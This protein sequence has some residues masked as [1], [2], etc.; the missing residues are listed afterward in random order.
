MLYKDSHQKL[1]EIT[2][3]CLTPPFPKAGDCQSSLLHVNFSC[4]M[5]VRRCDCRYPRDGIVFFLFNEIC[6]GYSSIKHIDEE[7]FDLCKE[8]NHED[9]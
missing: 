9:H 6:Q 2:N 1:V 7:I 5:D 3:S 8:N 4:G